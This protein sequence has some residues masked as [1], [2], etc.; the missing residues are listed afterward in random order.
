MRAE[1]LRRIGIEDELIL[2]RIALRIGAKDLKRSG[3]LLY[4]V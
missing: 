1:G 3:V 2:R 4:A